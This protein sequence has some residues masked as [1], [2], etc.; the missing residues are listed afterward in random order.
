MPTRCK[1]N[2][3][4]SVDWYPARSNDTTGVPCSLECSCPWGLALGASGTAV[5]T[6]RIKQK[7]LAE[8]T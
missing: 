8:C 2:P 5:F 6:G 3:E 1:K 4:S 7:Q